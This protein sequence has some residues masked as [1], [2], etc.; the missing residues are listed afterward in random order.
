[1][2]AWAQAAWIVKKMKLGTI[3]QEYQDRYDDLKTQILNT[4]NKLQQ[5]TN[6]IK[7]FVAVQNQTVLTVISTHLNSDSTVSTVTTTTLAPDVQ[8]YNVDN[9]ADG[10]LW[11]IL[12]Q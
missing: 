4:N 6:E 3:I 8:D 2:S 5:I 11:L 9:Y 1:M 10:C 12:D 7:T